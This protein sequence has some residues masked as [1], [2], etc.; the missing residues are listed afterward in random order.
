[1]QDYL[2]KQVVLFFR[3]NEKL[4]YQFIKNLEKKDISQKVFIMSVNREGYFLITIMGK[5]S[6][7]KYGR[8]HWSS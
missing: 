1:M 8:V 2:R 3:I 6:L 5:Q 4:D 7:T